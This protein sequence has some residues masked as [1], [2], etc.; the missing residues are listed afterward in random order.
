MPMK[1]PAV[2]GGASADSGARRKGEREPGALAHGRGFGANR[3]AMRG[4]RPHP[5]LA[6]ND[7]GLPAL[8]AAVQRVLGAALT[9]VRLP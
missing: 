4:E 7:V 5:R 8:P 2:A 3:N 1:K 9:W 6:A